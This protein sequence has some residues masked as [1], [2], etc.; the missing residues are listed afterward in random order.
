MHC[1]QFKHYLL[2][3]LRDELDATRR[4]ACEGHL[5]RCESC[6]V[7]WQSA[8]SEMTPAAEELESRRLTA[9][10]LQ[11]G[12]LEPCQ[13]SEELLCEFTDGELE[14]RDQSYLLRHLADCDAC[15]ELAVALRA[16]TPALAEESH[17]ES[18][19]DLTA[20]ILQRTS[21]APRPT[22]LS[23][24]WPQLA[25]VE[26]LQ[27][28][29]ARPR[30]ALEA[31]FSLTLAW[32]LLFGVPSGSSVAMEAETWDVIDAVQIQERMQEAQLGLN[33]GIERLPNL[34][35]QG[36]HAVSSG[37]TSLLQSSKRTVQGSADVSRT[38][39]RAWLEGLSVGRSGGEVE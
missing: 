16:L 12:G 23:A 3:L 11:G 4:D 18:A 9:R 24:W 17:K 21:R 5:E 39:L 15:S 32:V 38:V 13:Y 30:F 19:R 33:D 6:L 28:F 14:A 1:D 29:L 26:S 2:P 31:S 25:P 22:G 36:W 37:S 20:A 27:R 7:L 8:L 35:E 10:I 34:M